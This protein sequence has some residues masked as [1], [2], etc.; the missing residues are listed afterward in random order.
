[1][2]RAGHRRLAQGPFLEILHECPG[3]AEL[4]LSAWKESLFPSTASP[5][6][7][8]IVLN[9]N[10]WKNTMECLESIG[11]LEYDN[12]EVVLMD[13]ASSDGS[14]RN[15]HE[16]LQNKNIISSGQWQKK[17]DGS[18]INFTIYRFRSRRLTFI[19][20]DQNLGYAG[21]NNVGIEFSM[22]SD[23][24]FLWLLNND[25]VVEKRSLSELI[26][27]LQ[28]YGR[29]G[30]A[31]SVIMLYPGGDVAANL[32]ADSS[33][34]W[35][36][37]AARRSS[38]S[39]STHLFL[40]WLPGT[41]LFVTKAL[42]K[43]VG[44]L[45]ARFF[46]YSEDVDWSI[47]ARKKKWVLAC[48]LKSV[49]WHKGQGRSSSERTNKRFFNRVNEPLNIENFAKCGYYEVRNGVYLFRKHYPLLY[50]PYLVIRNLNLA[51][52]IVLFDDHKLYRMKIVAKGIVDALL[53]RMGELR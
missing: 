18:T 40:K 36:P 32:G 27:L 25:T 44:L 45:D 6:V 23:Y 26:C 12:F 33:V 11:R 37:E 20:L 22:R 21:G 10:G 39:G 17:T 8:I 30:M 2:L 5:R 7:A 34:Q 19:G 13:N 51:L 38:E 4:E 15:L 52:K 43:T 47:R 14:V 9:W 50:I 48:A 42:V 49:V 1:M 41:C 31:S 28:G 24:D 46:M 29:I 3:T 16:W 53:N 35:P